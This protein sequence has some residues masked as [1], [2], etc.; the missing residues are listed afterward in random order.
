VVV[1]AMKEVG[2]SVGIVVRVRKET[3]R[4]EGTVVRVQ[5]GIDRK[6]ID[7]RGTGHH[8]HREIV[9]RAP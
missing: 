2:E 7:R 9:R 1:S 6:G 3:D 4:E 8:V 5:W